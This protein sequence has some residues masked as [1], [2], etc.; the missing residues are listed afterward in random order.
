MH[1]NLVIVPIDNVDDLNVVKYLGVILNSSLKLPWTKQLKIL[2]AM[3]TASCIMGRTGSYSENNLVD[4]CK[5]DL[6]KPC[7]QFSV[8]NTLEKTIIDCSYKVVVVYYWS[9]EVVFHL[10]DLGKCVTFS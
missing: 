7:I 5:A 8:A 3:L 1:C 6:V 9:C 2:L 4:L 10:R